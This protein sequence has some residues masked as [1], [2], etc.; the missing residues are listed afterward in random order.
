M[1]APAIGTRTRFSSNPTGR[2]NEN[3]NARLLRTEMGKNCT[4][5]VYDTEKV[6]IEL[7]D[8]SFV[9]TDSFINIDL[10]VVQSKMKTK[11]RGLYLISSIIPASMYPA[12]F[13]RTSIPP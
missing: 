3:N 6:G 11:N 12:L 13:T 4:S 2:P 5:G 10:L 8:I 7:L 9:T 1:L